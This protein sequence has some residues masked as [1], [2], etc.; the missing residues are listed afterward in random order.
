MAYPCALLLLL[1][2][3]GNLTSRHA[4]QEE[5]TKL[6]KQI[7]ELEA[8]VKERDGLLKERDAKVSEAPFVS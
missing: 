4:T 5:N 8:S 2:Y 3:N 6:K 1:S 7:A